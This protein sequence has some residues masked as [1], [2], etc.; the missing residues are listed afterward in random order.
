MDDNTQPKQAILS[1]EP[2]TSE[3]IK[4]IASES[5]HP[6]ITHFFGPTIDRMRKRGLELEPK[7]GVFC[8][9]TGEGFARDITYRFCDIIGATI[10]GNVVPYGEENRALDKYL[11]ELDGP[12]LLALAVNYDKLGVLSECLARAGY[13]TYRV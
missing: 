5:S 7:A 10:H 4:M 13:D 6:G 11:S 1:L 3:L 9:R 2:L 12:V 8:G